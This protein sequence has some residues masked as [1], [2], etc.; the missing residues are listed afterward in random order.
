MITLQQVINGAPNP[1]VDWTLSTALEP[2][3]PFPVRI[4]ILASGK[5]IRIYLNQV[6]QIEVEKDLFR[7]GGLGFYARAAGD[8]PLTVNFSDLKIYEP[9]VDVPESGEAP[10]LENLTPNP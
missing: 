2:G 3:L 8:T 7:A 5:T 10:S 9:P 4:G 1:M 6:L